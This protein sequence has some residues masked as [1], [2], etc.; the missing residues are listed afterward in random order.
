M[1]DKTASSILVVDDMPDNVRL[2]SRLLTSH[3]YLVRS[4][5]NGDSAIE[6]AKKEC[7]DL[8]LMDVNL[9]GMN[10]LQTCVRLKED[11]QTRAVPV[12]F[13]SALDSVAHKV[14]GFQA[15]GVD[16]ITKPF[17]GKE[18]LARVVTHLSLKH[19]QTQFENTNR[20]LT[21]KVEELTRTQELLRERE[22][23]LQAF[24]AAVPNLSI[25][26]DENGRHLEV[27]ANVESMMAANASDLKNR[28]LKD[29]LDQEAAGII[30]TGIRQVIR[31]G[32]TRKVEYKIPVA[33]GNERWF[34]ARIALMERDDHGHGKVISVATDIT[35][36][37]KLYEEVQQLAIHDPLTG[38]FNRRHFLTLADRE[39]QRAVRYQRSISLLM[40]DIDHFKTYNDRY[41]HQTGDQLLVSLVEVCHKSLREVDILGRYGGDEF[42]ILM[43]E[44]GLQDARKAAERLRET[45]AG[46]AGES[47]TGNLALSVSIGLTA[48]KNKSSYEHQDLERLI[49][50][51]DRAMYKAKAAGRNCVQAA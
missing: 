33:A 26:Y 24:V 15:G 44:T 12:I 4:A 20:V 43:P 22:S 27:M 1:E 35:E 29:V 7:P 50:R 28:L 21:D 40:I 31:T 41:G 13:I 8:I 42:V 38:C 5:E 16:Y 49:Q 25:I 18:V 34:E 3:G 10:G 19:L 30:L 51:A 39:L 37:V 2:L 6:L 11:Q 14:D 47:S 17:D 32:K 48:W 9:P 23:K 46:M 36:R 45:I